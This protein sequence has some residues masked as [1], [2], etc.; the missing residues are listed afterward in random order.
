MKFVALAVAGLICAA[1]ATA[2]AQVVGPAPARGT[3][4]AGAS[5]PATSAPSPA[6][7]AVPAAPARSC[8]LVTQIA[9]QYAE[10]PLAG[11]DPAVTTAPLPAVSAAGAVMVVCNRATIIPEVTDYRVLTELRLPLSIRAGSKTL[12]LGASG[13]KLQVGMPEGQA[14]AEDTKAVQDRMDQ[15]ETAMQAQPA[16]K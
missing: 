14:T 11:F 9:G 16:K 4:A 15:M 1:T 2:H 3:P 8:L 6:A 7:A 13:G 5:A 10:A 12:F